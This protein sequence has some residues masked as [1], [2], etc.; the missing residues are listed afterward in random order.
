MQLSELA[1]TITPVLMVM[2]GYFL[3]KLVDTIGRLEVTVNKLNERT[4]VLTISADERQV[5]CDDRMSAVYGRLTEHD[6]TL[7]KHADRLQEH[8]L[9]IE[10]LSK[11]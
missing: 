4:M 11:K 10:K 7:D 1:L 9:K 8:E 5:R 3:K 2:L 6:N